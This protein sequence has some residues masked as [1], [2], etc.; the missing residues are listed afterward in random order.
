MGVV[1]KILFCFVF[2]LMLVAC[3]KKY[4]PGELRSILERGGTIGAIDSTIAGCIDKNCTKSMNFKFWPNDKN[5]SQPIFLYASLFDSVPHATEYADLKGSK[6]CIQVGYWVVTYGY[7]DNNGMET[8][9]E[10]LRN[11]LNEK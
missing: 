6:R 5:G 2:G 10:I 3:T 11:L 9:M 1:N 8:D 4:T 7:Q